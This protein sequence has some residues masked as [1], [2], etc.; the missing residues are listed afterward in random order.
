V[1]EVHKLAFL[2]RVQ[3]G[4]DL[5]G[6]GKVSSIDMH[7]LGILSDFEGIGHG[8]MA[9]LCG[10]DGTRRLSSLN[11]VVTTAVVASSMLSCSQSCARC[12]LAYTVI[13]PVGPGILSLGYA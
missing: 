7:G 5:H 11:L 4:P 2:F 12:V 10:V 8:G 6:S 13:I 3:S 1:E 9:R